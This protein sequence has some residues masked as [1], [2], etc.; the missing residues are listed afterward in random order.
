MMKRIW[1]WKARRAGGR[2]TINGRDE[3]GSPV[4]LANVD[5]IEAGIPFPIATHK[6]G[7]CFELVVGTHELSKP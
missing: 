3:A 6:D 4:K 2:I 7:E 1:F 5:A